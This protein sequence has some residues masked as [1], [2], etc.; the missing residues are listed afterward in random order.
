MKARA[1]SLN[2]D[3]KMEKVM[4]ELKRRLNIGRGY[5]NYIENQPK[6]FYRDECK[7][8][9][10]WWS[11]L[12]SDALSFVR[13]DSVKYGKLNYSDSKSFIKSVEEC[14]VKQPFLMSCR[15]LYYDFDTMILYIGTVI[16]DM[17]S[18]Y[19]PTD[20]YEIFGR[21]IGNESKS[22]KS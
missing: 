10:R 3:E 14:C 4:N 13:D 18:N 8:Y 20:P 22:N 1:A 21:R 2:N 12:I 9:K 19:Y 16:D 15:N 6:C 5:L 17:N 7:Q 11:V